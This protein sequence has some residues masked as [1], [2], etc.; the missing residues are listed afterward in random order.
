[1]TGSVPVFQ[2]LFIVSRCKMGLFKELVAGIGV[3]T[4]GGFSFFLGRKKIRVPL[5]MICI[6]HVCLFSQ[7]KE[8]LFR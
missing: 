7:Q 1:M 8:I 6:G 3:D 2:K 4:L 5:M